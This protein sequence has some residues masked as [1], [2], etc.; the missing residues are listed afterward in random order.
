M[1]VVLNRVEVVNSPLLKFGG[2]N[3]VVLFP[4]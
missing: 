1:D 3:Y 4:I 2:S